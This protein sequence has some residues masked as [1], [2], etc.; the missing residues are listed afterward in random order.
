MSKYSIGFLLV[1]FLVGGC[2]NIEKRDAFVS[3]IN[4]AVESTK[5]GCNFVPTVASIAA[6]LGVPGAPAAALLSK[7]IC[8]EIREIPQLE[9]GGEPMPVQVQ[10]E[11][12]KVDGLLYGD[13]E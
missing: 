1:V 4:T 12:G 6:I 7:Q 8:D 11:F 9:G 3:K 13:N 5:T 10:I 2:T